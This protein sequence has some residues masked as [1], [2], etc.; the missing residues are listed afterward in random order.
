MDDPLWY[1]NAVF[2]EVY[3]RAFCDSSGNGH[4]DLRGLIEK[5]DYIKD[6]GV[7]C[8]WLLPFYPSPL[9][10]DGYDIAEHYG[11]HSDYGTLED[12][13]EVLNAAHSRG[14]KVITD[15]VLNHTSDQHPWFKDA[16]SDPNS[17]YRDHYV[18]SDTTDRYVGARIIFLDTEVSNWTYDEVAKQFFWHRFYSSQ[19][20]LNFDNFDVQLEM[21]KVVSFWMDKGIAGFRADAVPYLFE[22]P[23]TN[24]ENLPE[25]HEY[26]KRLR[27]F[28]DEHYPGRIL[29]CEAN[30]WPEDVIEYFGDG[31]EFHMAF[32]FPVMPRIF[33]SLAMADRTPIV[34]ILNATP[35]IPEE[36]QWCT[37]LRNHDEL[38][39][40]MVTSEERHYMWETY[41][42]DPRMRL[43]LG[44]RRRLAP[45]LDG[46]RRKN[47]LL[48]SI[49]FSMPGSPIIYYGDEIGMG[50][51]IWLYDRDGVR[52]PMQ[53]DGNINAGFSDAPPDKL[54][55][56]VI[57]DE[58]YGY[59]KVNVASQ[60]NDPGSLLNTI[61]KM[62]R[63]RKENLV[64]GYGDYQ[65]LDV[66][67]PSILI[68]VRSYQGDCVY[69]V[70][71]LSD[72]PQTFELN[73]SLWKGDRLRDILN[74]K[75][76][77]IKGDENYR[78][79][80]TPYQYIWL[81]PLKD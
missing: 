8:I 26:L 32:H 5:M 58:T 73:S 69:A 30:Q 61:R 52:T 76:V 53:W 75:D 27:R 18:W 50:D 78:L 54:Y 48:N 59:E 57:D 62:I 20:D 43:N 77:Q 11:V 46:D 71:N 56:P 45:L 24:C 79:Q 33:M 67:T 25:T 21:F 42:P 68:F 28:V 2:Y 74:E 38:T 44:I 64:F 70:H 15:L 23:G 80:L 47:E 7:D 49:L 39:L 16:R 60:L 40:E 36:C 4:G 35:P 81:K 17:P 13:Q 29:L 3:I 12:F 34:Q 37:F 1:K 9:L 10:D 66:D 6:L 31:D 72:Q 19:P 51:N 22:R 14:L 41:A 65:I 55:A 63:V